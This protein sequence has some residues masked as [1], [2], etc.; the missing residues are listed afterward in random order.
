MI[1]A[2]RSNSELATS[3]H[4]LLHETKELIKIAPELEVKDFEYKHFN[5]GGIWASEILIKE[6]TLMVGNFYK[7]AHMINISKGSIVMDIAGFAEVYSAPLTVAIE[8]GTQKALIAIEE[9]IVTTYI[10][11]DAVTIDDMVREATTSEPDEIV[12]FHG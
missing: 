8:A 2:K 10:R 6:G 12:G 3:K 5:I 4:R 9:S 11:S 1:L 7:Q